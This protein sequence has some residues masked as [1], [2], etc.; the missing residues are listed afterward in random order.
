MMATEAALRKELA[1]MQQVLDEATA[2]NQEADFIIDA[3]VTLVDRLV[4]KYRIE[5]ERP[6][7]KRLE[8]LLDA[9]FS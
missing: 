7:K 4:D 6:E 9:Y 1:V 3:A 5:R 2:R 8:A